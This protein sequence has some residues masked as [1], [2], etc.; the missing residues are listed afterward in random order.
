MAGLLS[1]MIGLDMRLPQQV[2]GNGGNADAK[3]LGGLDIAGC[4]GLVGAG[5]WSSRSGKTPQSVCVLP[6]LS[7]NCGN[8]LRNGAAYFSGTCSAACGIVMG[9]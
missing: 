7:S 1:A 9:R 8:F 4:R 5:I 6:I 3:C 2:A